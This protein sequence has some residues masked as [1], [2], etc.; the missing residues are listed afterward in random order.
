MKTDTETSTVPAMEMGQVGAGGKP[1]LCIISS[2]AF[3]LFTSSDCYSESLWQ[4][5]QSLRYEFYE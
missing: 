3:S 5:L 2:S 1:E 4:A